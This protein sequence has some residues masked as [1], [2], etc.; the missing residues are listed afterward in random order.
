M[1]NKQK[2]DYLLEIA[3]SLATSKISLKNVEK[4]VSCFLAD[5]QLLFCI[6]WFC[7]SQT[8]VHCSK[9]LFSKKYLIL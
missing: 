1:S 8:L 4:L 5:R 2:F 3:V 7:P 6:R 9:I